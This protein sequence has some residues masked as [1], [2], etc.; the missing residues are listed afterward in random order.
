MGLPVANDEYYPDNIDPFVKRHGLVLSDD[1][2]GVE[3][4]GLDDQIELLY[5]FPDGRPALGFQVVV[6]N[7]LFKNT[8]L[9]TDMEEAWLTEVADPKGTDEDDD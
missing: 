9:G 5:R 2:S 3:P 4:F 8:Y 7:L 1:R 6:P